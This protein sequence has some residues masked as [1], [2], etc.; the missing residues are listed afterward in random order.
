[1]LLSIMHSSSSTYLNQC[2][3]YHIYL[4]LLYIIIKV[5]QKSSI[6]IH[7]TPCFVTVKFTVTYNLGLNKRFHISM[8]YVL[9]KVLLS[10]LHFHEYMFT[11]NKYNTEYFTATL[12]LVYRCIFVFFFIFS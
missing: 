7:S 6:H 1:M 2:F 4:S 11:V 10:S 9:S 3:C 12:G 5:L 8:Q